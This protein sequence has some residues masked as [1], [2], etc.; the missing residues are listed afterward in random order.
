MSIP[1]EN[2]QRKYK[3]MIIRGAFRK[4]KVTKNGVIYWGPNSRCLPK[5]GDQEMGRF[6]VTADLEGLLLRYSARIL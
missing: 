6:S 1:V 5:R 3:L 2:I 4:L